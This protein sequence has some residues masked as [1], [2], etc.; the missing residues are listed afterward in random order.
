MFKMIS[1]PCS[2]TGSFL[3]ENDA[4]RHGAGGSFKKMKSIPG[5]DNIMNRDDLER[6]RE[7]DL[8]QDVVERWNIEERKRRGYGNR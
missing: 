4:R 5:F 2:L 7:R 8:R 6:S 1:P 3:T